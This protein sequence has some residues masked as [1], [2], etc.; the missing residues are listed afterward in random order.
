MGPDAKAL[1]QTTLTLPDGTRVVARPIQ[2]HD[3]RALQRFHRRLSERSI[4]LR[5][6][7]VVPELSDER[8]RYFTHVDGHDRF[9]F[10]ALDPDEPDEIIGVVRFD[11]EAGTNTGEYAVIVEDRWQGRGVGFAL[12]RLLIAAARRRG[13]RSMYALVLPEN[14]RMI[15][16]LRDLGLPV[17]SHWVDGMERIEVDISVPEQPSLA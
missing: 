1:E 14:V 8:A 6:F 10:I 11:R 7:G 13:Y 4:Y 2:P 9:A 12:T 16:L 3:M 15:N 17:R 5:F